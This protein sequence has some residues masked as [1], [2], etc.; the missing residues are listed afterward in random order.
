LL[1]LFSDR[2]RSSTISLY[3][4]ETVDEVTEQEAG[5]LNYLSEGTNEKVVFLPTAKSS[6]EKKEQNS[7]REKEVQGATLGWLI[8]NM[9]VSLDGKSGIF[10]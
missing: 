10:N 2:R 9:V 7:S 5:W 4:E 1:T 3:I 8:K 6:S